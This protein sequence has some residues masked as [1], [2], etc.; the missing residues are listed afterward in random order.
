MILENADEGFIQESFVTG[1]EGLNDGDSI[2]RLRREI[3][4]LDGYSSPPRES[5]NQILCPT[6]NIA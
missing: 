4:G 3:C 5:R 2:G 1:R 6:K